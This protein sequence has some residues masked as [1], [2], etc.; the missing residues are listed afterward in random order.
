MNKFLRYCSLAAFCAGAAGRLS[1][2]DTAP[3]VARARSDDGFVEMEPDGTFTATNGVVITHQSMVLSADRVSGNQT[4]GDIEAEGS[5]VLTE[6]DPKRGDEFWTGDRAHYNLNTH[7]L[8]ANHFKTGHEPLYIDG[9][10]LQGVNVGQTNEVYTA[11]NA[12]ITTDNY[13]RPSQK[14]RARKIT[15]VPGKYVEAEDAVI[16][17]DGV[18]VMYLP[19]YHRSLERHLNNFAF[20]PGYRSLFGPYMLSTFNWYLNQEIS[21]AVHGDYYADRGLGVGAD[22]NLNLGD[23]GKA[24]F[25]Y[26]YIHD[27]NPGLDPNNTPIAKERERASFSYDVTLRTNLTVK[28][29]ARYQSDAEMIRDFFESEYRKNAQPNSFAEVNQTWPNFTLNAMVQPQLV[30]SFETVERLPDVQLNALR[31]QIGQTPF[32]YESSSDGAYLDRKYVNPQ[33][34]FSAARFDTFHQITMP[35]TF[36]GFLTIAPRVGERLTYYS[37]AE[38]PGATTTE[39]TRSIFNTGLEISMKASRVWQNIESRFWEVNGLRHVVE[40]TIDYV[41]VPTPNVLPAQIPQFDYE[42]PAL[43]PLPIEFTDYNSIDSVNSQNVIR[44]AL[45]NRLQT[46]RED[47]IDNMVNWTLSLDW[48]IRPNPTE[49]TYGDFYS[50]LRFKPRSWLTFGST[51]RYDINTGQWLE[52]DSRMLIQPAT[53]WSLSI[54]HRYLAS[55]PTLGPI[56]GAGNNTIYGRIFYKMNENWAMAMSQHFEAAEGIW[57]SQTYTIYRDLRSWT[58]AFT[59]RYVENVGSPNDLTV[60][61]AFSLKAMPHYHL[62]QDSDRPETLFGR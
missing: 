58:A 61:V 22:V 53:D 45:Y 10:S 59:V 55:D 38:G 60:A 62:G 4:T 46:K 28:V 27:Q 3:L 11:R 21:G 13:Q 5:V 57:Q 48:H 50:D 34:D 24:T 54:G 16:Y 39:Q 9:G 26:Y 23:F 42:I 1:A 8:E 41:Y 17:V 18:P 12:V 35:E 37:Q 31:Q 44:F 47:K 32:Y 33:Y 36:F 6:Q 30:T 51:V 25:K 2:A 29:E 20:L 14:I 19:Y 40:P 43:R 7:A 56:Y 52:S 49:G 15:Y